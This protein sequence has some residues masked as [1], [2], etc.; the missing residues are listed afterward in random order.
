[1]KNLKLLFMLSACGMLAF[2]SCKKDD[3]DDEER[4]IFISYT[5]NGTSFTLTSG[6]DGISNSVG[7]ASGFGQYNFTRMYEPTLSGTSTQP[8][9]ELRFY[10]DDSFSDS[11][12][13]LNMLATGSYDYKDVTGTSSATHTLV[14]IVYEDGNGVDWRTDGNN[15]DYNPAAHSFN[16]TGHEM[17]TTNDKSRFYTAGNFSCVLYE[18]SGSDSLVLTN[19]SFELRTI[20][21]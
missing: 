18:V 14:D 10:R 6:T 9:I 13:Y 2:T 16:I 11:T 7:K 12:V 15:S 8:D 21:N 3:P 4:T 1:M 5:V 19:G 20:Q 17:N